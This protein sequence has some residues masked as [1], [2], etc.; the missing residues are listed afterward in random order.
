MI[1]NVVISEKP[2]RVVSDTKGFEKQM[3]PFYRWCREATAHF[4]TASS[5]ETEKAH[6]LGAGSY[7]CRYYTINGIFCQFMVVATAP[8]VAR[9]PGFYYAH[10][11]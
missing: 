6:S 5:Y 9:L 8:E 4:L 11:Q 3:S 1:S 7:V 2:P 10:E